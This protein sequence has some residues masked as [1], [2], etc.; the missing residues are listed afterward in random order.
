MG[1]E[2]KRQLSEE[3]ALGRLMRLCARAERCSGDALRLMRGWGIK[4]DAQ[5]RVLERLTKERFVDDRRY[6]EAFFREKSRLSGWGMYKIEQSLRVKGIDSEI[7][8]SLAANMDDKESVQRLADKLRRKLRTIKY[9]SRQELRAKL[10]RYGVSLGY[11]FE[12][13]HSQVAQIVQSINSDEEEDLCE[14]TFMF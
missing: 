1:A 12:Q 11:D 7:I 13:I 14:D 5:K 6:A 8:S 3:Q 2:V 9:S 4:P 10:T